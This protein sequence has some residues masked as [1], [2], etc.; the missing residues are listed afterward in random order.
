MKTT[1][2]MAAAAVLLF[3]LAACAPEAKQ[4]PAVDAMRAAAEAESRMLTVVSAWVEA[5]DSGNTDNLNEIAVA[6]YQRTGPDQNVDSLED[7]KVFMAQVHAA[8]ADYQLTHDGAAAGPDGAFLQWTVTGIDSVRAGA[9]GKPVKVTGFSRYT[10][11]D[12]KIATELVVFDTAAV[13]AQ[14]TTVEMPH[15]AE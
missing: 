13:L 6:D 14:L 9:T 4:D 11:V 10:F 5:W 15:M 2:K 3:V 8:Y 12:G 7:M 1:I